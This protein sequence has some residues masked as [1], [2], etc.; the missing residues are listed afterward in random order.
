MGLLDDAIREHLELKR[1]RGADAEEVDPPGAGGARPAAARRVR[2]SARCPPARRRAC[3]RT[4]PPP[5]RRAP[6]EP[7][8]ETAEHAVAEPEPEPEPEPRDAAARRAGSTAEP[9]RSRLPSRRSATRSSST[10][11][12][13]STRRPP[14]RRPRARTS[15]RRR[16]T[17]CRRRRSTTG[18]GSSRSRRATSTSTASHDTVWTGDRFRGADLL[19]A[20]VLPKRVTPTEPP[21]TGR[22]RRP[23]RT[24]GRGS[25]RTTATG[26]PPAPG[27]SFARPATRTL[28]GRVA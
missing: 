9:S 11:R 14:S 16:R 24:P 10:S 5:R 21:W 20:A 4:G 28:T 13:P 15:S 2:G 17:S 6:A 1:R 18:C 22:T 3:R 19:P 26:I 25:C 23:P 12:R 8:P 27:R 7:A